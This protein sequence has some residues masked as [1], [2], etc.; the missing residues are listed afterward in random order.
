MAHQLLKPTPLKPGDKVAILSPAWSAPSYFP[1]I[2]RQ[3]M[4]R[5]EKLL[6]LEPV[7]YPTTSKM[8]AS[9][10]ERAEDVNAAFADPE[11][12]AIF[13]TIGGDDEITVTPHLDS[14]LPKADPKPFFGYSD[15]TNISNWLWQNGVG[16]YYGGS[17]MVHLGPAQVDE[18]HLTTLKAALFAEGDLQLPIPTES[19]DFGHDW[20]SPAA[21]D[22]PYPRTPSP[23]LEFLASDEKVR[24]ATWGGCLEV[25]DQ[26]ALADRLPSA[27]Q[28]EGKILLFETSEI[29]PPPE[30]VGRWIR[31]LGQ[32]GYLD[33]ASALAF[34]QPVVADRDNPMPPEILAAKH[35]AY[36]EYLL[37]NIAPY[38]SD[39]LVC[40]NLP[41]GHTRPQLVLPYGG[42]ITLDPKTETVTAHY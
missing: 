21:L 40:L 10:K 36:V 22:Q 14:Q 38:R 34:A 24:G 39:L 1:Q 28:I 6:G 11:I 15:N 33:A 31:A 12:R 27:E 26:L 20:S 32:R 3:A 37:A 13:T 42:E 16:S 8:G 17:T 25:I 41:F 2:H 4:E 19:E 29:I 5:V 35:E 30:Y 23:K 18:E 7:E 9:P